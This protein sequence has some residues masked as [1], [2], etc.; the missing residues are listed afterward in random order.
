MS[1]CVIIQSSA[2]AHQCSSVKRRMFNWRFMLLLAAICT[3]GE[4]CAKPPRPPPPLP[5][6]PA[7]SLSPSLTKTTVNLDPTTQTVK[8]QVT[9]TFILPSTPLHIPLQPNQCSSGAENIADPI[10]VAG[11]ADSNTLYVLANDQVTCTGHIYSLKICFF[12][13]EPTNSRS[14]PVVSILIFRQKH[15]SDVLQSYQKVAKASFNVRHVQSGQLQCQ[16][17]KPED[18]VRLHEGDTLGFISDEDINIVLVTSSEKNLFAYVPEA[19]MQGTSNSTLSSIL[20]SQLKQ[21]NESVTPLLKVVLS[22][23]SYCRCFCRIPTNTLLLL[24][25]L[26]S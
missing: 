6:S 10:E 24:F 23:C 9:P 16:Y 17:I 1:R 3:V 8:P 20:G 2:H 13:A 21:L 22:K 14:T 11:Y 25:A 4:V 12:I 26:L 7:I 19:A 5:P 15:S 18:T